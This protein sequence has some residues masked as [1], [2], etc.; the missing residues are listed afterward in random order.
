MLNFSFLAFLT[1]AAVRST[2]P[3]SWFMDE[4]PLETINQPG[5]VVYTLHDDYFPQLW[6]AATVRG[7]K[8]AI[9]KQTS[10][11]NTPHS[12]P[13]S[14]LTMT[15]RGLLAFALADR[16][17]GVDSTSPVIGKLVLIH[18]AYHTLFKHVIL[19]DVLY[20]VLFLSCKK[21]SIILLLLSYIHIV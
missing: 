17:H 8:Q 3:T 12:V 11:A 18:P 10:N 1:S 5:F 21:L 16:H 7:C 4:E 19:V 9:I 6:N 15:T 20:R 14:R 13:V 2:R